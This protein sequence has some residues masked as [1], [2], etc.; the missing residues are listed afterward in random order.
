MGD[1]SATADRDARPQVRVTYPDGVPRGLFT[2]RSLGLF[3]LLLAVVAATTM[4]GFWQL[5]VAQDE[6]RR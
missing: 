3:V 4:L 5:G 1:E 6:G 2:A